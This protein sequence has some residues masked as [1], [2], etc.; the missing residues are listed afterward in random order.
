VTVE[1]AACAAVKL[2]D[3]TRL[4]ERG[5]APVSGTMTMVEGIRSFTGKYAFLSNFHLSP[6]TVG[7]GIIYPSGEHAF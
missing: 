5:C 3:D 2:W 6:V 1:R 7:D 4:R